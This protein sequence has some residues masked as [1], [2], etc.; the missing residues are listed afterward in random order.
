MKRAR[1]GFVALVVFVSLYGF[2]AE[3]PYTETINGITWGY[4]LLSN[5]EVS[6]CGGCSEQAYIP[7]HTVSPISLSG[8]ILI[9]PTLGGK[10]VTKIGDEAFKG[11]SGLTRV[12]IPNG[13]K[14]IGNRVFQSCSG[15]TGITIPISVTSIGRAAFYNCRGLTSIT[16]REGIRLARFAG[17]GS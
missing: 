5:T 15:L 13:V 16:I 17:S 11:Y 9:P 7:G 6:L 14:S 12:T 10:T 4:K 2:A 1:K 8:S 3:W